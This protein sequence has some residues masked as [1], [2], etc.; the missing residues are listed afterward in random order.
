MNIQDGRHYKNKRNIILIGFMGTGKSTVGAALAKR[1]G[2]TWVDT[3]QKI[4][5]EENRPINEVFAKEGE[6]YF[7][8]RETEVL[9]SLLR[10]RCQVITTGGGIVL[11]PVNRQLMLENGFVV[12]L[13]ASVETIV[14]RLSGDTTRPLLQGDIDSRVRKLLKER[15]GLYDFADLSIDTTEKTVSD[16]I[17]EIEKVTK[18]FFNC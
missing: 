18:A 4:E 7:R 16:V 8:R 2:W 15:E 9:Q 1:V 5:A 12:S 13:K 10:N 6:G 14:S 3:D 17:G 11:S